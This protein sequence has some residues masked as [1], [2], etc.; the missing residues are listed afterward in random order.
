[1]KYSLFIAYKRLFLVGLLLL[2]ASCGK[3]QENHKLARNHYKLALLELRESDTVPLQAGKRAL[4]AIERAIHIDPSAE[5]YAFKATL[6]LRL[7]HV[8]ASNE[9]FKQ[10]ISVAKQPHVLAEIKNNYACVLAE[11]GDHAGAQQLWQEL[12]HD[13]DYL[14]PEVALVNQGKL[15]ATQG[16]YQAAQELFAR[17]TQLAPNYIDAHFYTALVARACGDESYARNAIGTVLFLDPQHS[18]ARELATE[19]GIAT[20]AVN[21]S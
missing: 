11:Q 17:A 16:E 4:S 19:M 21:N 9:T 5:Y 14:T 8:D 18:P 2:T 6:L 3:K 15:A 7:G 13:K 10:A 12:V 1:M 20:E